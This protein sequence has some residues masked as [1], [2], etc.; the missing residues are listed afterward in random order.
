[1]ILLWH[2]LFMVRYSAK[3]VAK[4]RPVFSKNVP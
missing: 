3:Y 2:F 4:E 1:M